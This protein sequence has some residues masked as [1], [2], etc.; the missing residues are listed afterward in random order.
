MAAAC[1]LAIFS[2]K[3]IYIAEKQR[4][5]SLLFCFFTR[6]GLK[7][8]LDKNLRCY[9]TKDKGKALAAHVVS[10]LPALSQKI[11]RLG[12]ETEAVNLFCF[13]NNVLFSHSFLACPERHPLRSS[14]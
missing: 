5:R 12:L 4:L 13:W 11:D 3:L 9:Y 14:T 6:G 7:V 10:S 1:A 8:Y 2:G